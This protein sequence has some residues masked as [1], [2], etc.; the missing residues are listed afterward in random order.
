MA[1]IIS[2][3]SGVSV[4]ND[5][6][7]NSDSYYPALSTVTAGSMT[8][9]YVSSTKFYYNPSTGTLNTTNYN[10][11]SDASVKTN[12]TPVV[13][14]TSTLMQIEGV[15]FYWKDNGLKSAGV[16]AQQLESILPHLVTESSEGIKSVNY[17]GLIA[18]LIESNKELHRRIEVLECK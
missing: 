7:T 15:E 3:P 13:G 12:V 17:S 6:S 5:T 10:S 16:I 4:A 2:A 14:A 11:L 8:S 1:L 9:G 18:Y